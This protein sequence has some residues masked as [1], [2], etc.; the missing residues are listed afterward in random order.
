MGKL[1]RGY[2]EKMFKENVRHQVGNFSI[3]QNYC[4][5]LHL[6]AGNVN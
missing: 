5:V 6:G 4:N 2:H 1:F 3:F